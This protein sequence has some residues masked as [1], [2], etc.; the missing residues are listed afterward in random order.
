MIPKYSQIL[1]LLVTISLAGCSKEDHSAK[2]DQINERELYGTWRLV[3]ST[4]INWEINVEQDRLADHIIYRFEPDNK[5]IISRGNP[6]HDVQEHQYE[7]GTVQILP[8]YPEI[9]A[10]FIDGSRWGIGFKEDTLFISQ[11][12]VDGESLFFERN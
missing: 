6:V 11:A 4:F 2:D 7:I 3:K 12:Y 5:L 10:L 9:T 8:T 1:I